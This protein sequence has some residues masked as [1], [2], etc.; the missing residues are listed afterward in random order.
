MAR[1]VHKLFGDTSGEPITVDGQ[2]QP[3]VESIY[4]QWQRSNKQAIKLKAR[5]E[6][7]QDEIL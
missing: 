6:A 7:Y 1:W 4:Q 5:V 2:L 3:L